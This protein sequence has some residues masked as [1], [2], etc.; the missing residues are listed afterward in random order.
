MRF[1]KTPEEKPSKLDPL[2]D[3]IIMSMGGMDETDETYQTA[4]AS[5]RMLLEAKALEPKQK[6]LDPNTVA[7][8]AGNLAGIALILAFEMR[9]VITSKSMNFVLKPKA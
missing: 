1:L 4:A 9:N 6:E 7:V 3:D 5:L 2:I 8:I